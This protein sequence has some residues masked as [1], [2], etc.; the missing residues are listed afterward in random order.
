MAGMINK[1]DVSVG[2][3]DGCELSVDLFLPDGYDPHPALL[4]MSPYGKEIQS[5]PIR[6]QPVESSAYRRSIEAGDPEMLTAAGY[7]HVIADVRGIGKSDG[8]YRGWMSAEEGRDGHDL[9]EWIAAQPW[10]DGNVGMVGVSYYGSVQLN[11]AA[12]Q[13]PHLK[14]IMPW[15]APA[16]FYREATH[17]GGIRQAFMW[18]L[19]GIGIR[20]RTVVTT[21]EESD[22]DGFAALINDLAADPDLQMY[23]DLYNTVVN[24]D[25]IPGY[26]DVLAHPLDGPFYEER[27][28][29]SRYQD[30]H[31]PCYFGSAWW[32]YAH[33][34]LR[35]AFQNY[36]GIDAPKKLRIRGRRSSEA[37]LP[38]TFNREVIRWY[39]HWLKGETSGI[40]D[41]PPI[42]LFIMGENR[43]RAEQEWP[44]ARAQWTKL[45][46]RRWSGLSTE[47]EESAGAPDCFV[48]QPPDE[49]AEIASVSY[50]T[51]PLAEDT[52]ITGPLALYLHAS[53]DSTDANWIAA[54]SDVAPDGSSVEFSRGFLKAS[55][56]A[57]DGDRSRPWQPYHP[58]TEVEA[59]PKDEVIEYAI[60]MS[61]TANVFRTGHRIQLDI[62]GADNPRN[63]GDELELGFGHRPWHVVRAETV[64]HRVHHGP[65][66]PS[67]LLVPIIPARK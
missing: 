30:I 53:I 32:A 21:R 56:R 22:D 39:D 46:L 33:M 34:H 1:V 40:L 51:A 31:I 26:F 58:H 27:S 35:G 57:I 8:T 9:V 49:T 60:E 41:E 14:A 10:C 3:R 59:V 37:P 62:T 2:M 43:F 47:P 17:H 16:D 13:P 23:P 36:N 65:H 29:Y 50:S 45:F 64:L 44:P 24:P 5:L 7:V 28:P 20:G 66:H 42:Q 19:Y 48:Q 52:E 38:E 15:N 4:A 6:P 54:L 12:T 25:R 55:H 61:P 18:I 63:P 67:H 11:V